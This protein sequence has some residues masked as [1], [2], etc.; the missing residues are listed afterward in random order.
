MVLRVCCWWYPA[1][2]GPPAV[3]LQR[4]CPMPGVTSGL[5][6]TACLVVRHMSGLHTLAD[7]DKCARHGATEGP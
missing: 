6:A 1:P 3:L 4:I 2:D 7:E 5:C